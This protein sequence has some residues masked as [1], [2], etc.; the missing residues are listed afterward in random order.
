VFKLRKPNLNQVWETF[1]ELSPEEIGS[2]KHIEKM[3]SLIHPLVNHLKDIGMIDWYCFLIHPKSEVTKDPNDTAVGFHLRL[4]LT[5]DS[6]LDEVCR[7]LPKN[8]EGTRK[9]SERSIGGIDTNLLERQDIT[10][11][12]R[13]I[14]EQSEWLLNMLNI[15]K[16]GANIF[17]EQIGQFLHYYFNMTQLVVADRIIRWP[18]W[19]RYMGILKTVLQTE[20]RRKLA[21]HRS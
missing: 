3:R 8:C 11:A 10:E 9:M 21:E 17:P 2:G 16:E 19:V 5:K 6:S 12:W 18:E 7:L 1:I 20:E 13:V 15:Y 4:S 14:G